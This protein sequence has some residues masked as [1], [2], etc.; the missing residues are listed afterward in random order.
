MEENK[1]FEERKSQFIKEYKELIDKYRI[2]WMSFPM[3]TP[4]EK[5]TWEITIQTH[6][7]DTKNSPVKSPFIPQ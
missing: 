4:N 1:E 2:D 3:F 7:V 6:P 5:G